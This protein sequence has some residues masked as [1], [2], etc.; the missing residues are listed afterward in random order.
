MDVLGEIQQLIHSY[1]PAHVIY[2]GDMNA[3]L[4]R[5]TLHAHALRN[6]IL[7]FNL[8]VCIDAPEA[9]VAYTYVYH[10]NQ[11]GR[12]CRLHV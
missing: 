6:F 12:K 2:G 10:E 8:T 11:V 3:D 9:E 1:N 4:A 7:D 5:S